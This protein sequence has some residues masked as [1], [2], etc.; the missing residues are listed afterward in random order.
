[1]CQEEE[2]EE[3]LPVKSCTFENHVYIIWASAAVSSQ[4]R[5]Y[6]L[7]IYCVHMKLNLC[8]TLQ[9]QGAMLQH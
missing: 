3:N 5:I 6:L 8:N 9:T 4:R 2:D 1:M 7:Y